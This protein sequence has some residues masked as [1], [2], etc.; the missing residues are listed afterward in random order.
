VAAGKVKE[1][2]TKSLFTLNNDRIVLDTIKKAE[3]RESS[4]IRLHEMEGSTEEVVIDSSYSIGRWREVNL[5]EDEGYMD[6]NEGPINLSFT[7]YE[8]KTIELE[9][10]R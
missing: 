5:M 9:F 7:P 6:F 10:N 1:E 4:I 8:V 2:F 3:D